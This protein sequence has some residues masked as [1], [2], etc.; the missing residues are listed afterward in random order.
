MY[1]CIFNQWHHHYRHGGKCWSPRACR[2]PRSCDRLIC[3]RGKI[4]VVGEQWRQA[5]LES[6]RVSLRR[7]SFVFAIMIISDD[8]HP[9][10]HLPPL[11]KRDFSCCVHVRWW[12]I[13]PCSRFTV[14]SVGK[15]FINHLLLLQWYALLSCLQI[16]T[17]CF[18]TFDLLTTFI[19]F[20]DGAF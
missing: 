7:P 20:I 2:M 10:S 6:A 11:R 1:L 3:K 4:I 14:T 17:P 8:N 15:Y 19:M 18:F 5:P 12:F 13:H 16:I 9:P